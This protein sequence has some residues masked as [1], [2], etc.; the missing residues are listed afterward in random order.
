MTLTAIVSTTIWI[1]SSLGSAF[2]VGRF[3]DEAG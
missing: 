1:I 2:L 3:A